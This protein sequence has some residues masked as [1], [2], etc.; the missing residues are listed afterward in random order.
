MSSPSPLVALPAELRNEIFRLAVT[1]ERPIAFNF[2]P[3]EPG[4]YYDESAP[5]ERLVGPEQPALSKTSRQLRREVLPIFYGVNDI[6][7]DMTTSPNDD[8]RGEWWLQLQKYKPDPKTQTQLTLKCNVDVHA[9]ADDEEII[10]KDQRTI[11]YTI[12]QTTPADS[13][14]DPVVAVAAQTPLEF[15]LCSCGALRYADELN[16]GTREILGGSAVVAMCALLELHMVRGKILSREYHGHCRVCGC[17]TLIARDR[18][19]RLVALAEARVV[20]EEARQ[21]GSRVW[22]VVR[23]VMGRFTG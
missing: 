2:L 10:P 1:Q 22:R 14:Q 7:I 12:T 19:E 23:W 17:P 13:S 3:N 21:A 16:S 18:V 8:S 15:G 20:A 4:F 6:I 5:S 11:S 9:D